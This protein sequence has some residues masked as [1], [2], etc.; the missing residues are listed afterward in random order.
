MVQ[1]YELSHQDALS[2]LTAIQKELDRRG[3]GA[4]VAVT[5]SQGELLAFLR[6]DGCKLPSI[7]IAINKAYTAARERTESK[8][9][10]Q[11]SKDEE[12]PMTN[13]GDL[14][15]TA[16]GGGVPIVYQDQVVGAVGVSGLPESEDME[17]ARMGAALIN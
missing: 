9:V 12:F 2:V 4:A 16:W 14:R 3:K 11:A 17:L 13:F 6:T 7:T 1:R 15:Y 10:G 5:D 8:A